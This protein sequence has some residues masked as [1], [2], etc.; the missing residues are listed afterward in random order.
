VTLTPIPSLVFLGAVAGGV[1]QLVSLW[2]A[3]WLLR[4]RRPAAGPAALP[5][6]TVLKPVHGAGDG[7]YENLASF[8]RQDYPA[9]QIVIG[10]DDPDDPAVA[11]V[12]RLK[13][14]FPQ[15]DIVLAVGSLPGA[16]RKIANVLQM[17]RHARHDVLVL[18]D[19]DV[20]V[21]PDY[22]AEVVAPLAEPEVGLTTCLY[23]AV[24][25]RGL[26]ALVES[27]LINT[28]F[29]PMALTACLRPLRAA[30]GAT[31][32]VKR[33][34]LEAIGGFAALRDH[35]ADDY[36]LGRRV[37][38]AGWRVELLP[39]V[40]ETSIDSATLG[41]VWRHQL[42]WVR[43][44][45]V[46]QPLGW[47]LSVVTHA[48]LW[49]VIGFAVFAEVPAGWKLLTALVAVRLVTLAVLMLRLGEGRALR[50]L[51]L[52]PA[53]DVMATALWAAGFLGR[54]VEWGG[55]AYLVRRDGSML[56]LTPAE[57]PAPPAP[58]ELPPPAAR[59]V[60]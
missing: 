21:R 9:H 56:A 55:R 39:Y 42:R 45:R 40:V 35:L 34:A 11:V 44:Y 30:F 49:G 2:A 13:R 38:E 41:D 52:V 58:V 14:D 22:L 51:W 18:S 33:Q 26:P 31:M 53:T 20:R 59:R 27:L 32:A 6:V 28:W 5:P 54:R 50:G 19:A 43:T 47:A 3:L 36:Q 10:V 48:T 8:C 60:S 17:M 29:I 23:R 57:V 46:C 16:N 24:G 1:F 7:L 4:R 12:R 37:A 25:G 15:L